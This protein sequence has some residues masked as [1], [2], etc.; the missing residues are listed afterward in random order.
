MRKDDD[1][2]NPMEQP[3]WAPRIQRFSRKELQ[4][5]WPR[6]LT[7]ESALYGSSAHKATLKDLG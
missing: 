6:V 2:K 7:V 1:K 3:V 4:K 5:A